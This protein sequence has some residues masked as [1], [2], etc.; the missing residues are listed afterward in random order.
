MKFFLLLHFIPLFGIEHTKAAGFCPPFDSIAPVIDSLTILDSTTND[1]NLWVGNGW[2][3]FANFQ[4]D[5]CEAA[6]PLSLTLIDSCGLEDVVIKYRLFM[7][8]DN[9]GSL[10][11]MV[12]PEVPISPGWIRYNNLGATPENRLFDARTVPDQQKWRFA[13][14]QKVE[15]NAKTAYVRFNTQLSPAVYEPAQLPHGTHQIRWY[16]SNDCGNS[17][18]CE[19][20]VEIKDGLPPVVSCI[21]SVFKKFVFPGVVQIWAGD[22]LYYT[23][24]NCSHSTN[25]TYG[26]RKAGTGSGFPL[27]STG[28]TQTN[29]QYVCDDAVFQQV[30]LW[31]KDL[32]GN[33]SFCLSTVGLIDD[34]SGACEYDPIIFV[35]GKVTTP[36]N[37]GIDSVILSI[38]VFQNFAPDFEIATA[39]FTDT[40]GNYFY[41]SLPIA[42]D[43]I[44]H[45]KLD[46][47][48][49][50]GITTF[51]LV[52]ISKHILGI[53]AL[54]SPLKIIAA[55]ANRSNSITTFDIVELRKL[56]L[57][58]YTDLPNNTSWRFLRE[59]HFFEDPLNPFSAPLP[60][61]IVRPFVLY[62]QYD[63][64]FWGI[65]IGDVNNSVVP[66]AAGLSDDRQTRPAYFDMHTDH[67]GEVKP[68]EV[69]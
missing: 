46:R 3:D 43:V 35:F 49:L 60:D 26:L 25:L 8:L 18:S 56:L 10:E 34:G 68:G 37:S 39:D 13:M 55:D 36:L 61:N 24:D 4:P 44:I 15:G 64:N 1:N 33:T 57:G 2:F 22:I 28:N 32:A 6:A 66:H 29:I 59:N 30:E 23:S 17:D 9:N 67:S 31:S 38:K 41:Q 11:T 69:F 48:F 51:D 5:L 45:P 21:S 16:F 27:D 20:E 63:V 54:D 50:N 62:N 14:E 53:E 47:Y 52:L 42:S 7:D 58:I 12:D 40:S 19:Y 65:K